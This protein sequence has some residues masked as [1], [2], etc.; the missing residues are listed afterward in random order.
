MSGLPGS[1]VGRGTIKGTPGRD[2]A[3]KA[4]AEVFGDEDK[5]RK[6]KRRAASPL[7]ADPL[8]INQGIR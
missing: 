1:S 4:K 5:E 7:T 8:S 2:I 6:R 3:D